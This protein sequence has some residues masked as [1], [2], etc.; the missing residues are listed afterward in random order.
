MSKATEKIDKKRLKKT[1]RITKS[2]SACKK[3]KVKC[4]F[5]IPC[6]PCIARGRAHLCTKDPILLDGMLVDN[7]NNIELKYSQEN[8]VLKKKIKILQD[9][10]LKLK[11]QNSLHDHNGDHSSFISEAN[12]RNQNFDDASIKETNNFRGNDDINYG[13]KANEVNSDYG[14]N[15]LKSWNTYSV[16]LSLLEKGLAN[17]MTDIND[18]NREET[19]KMDY[20]TE[21]WLNIPTGNIANHNKED[22][23]GNVWHYQLELIGR[24]GF[25]ECKYLIHK[26][27]EILTLWPIL[28]KEV[29]LKQF[30]QF[31]NDKFNR[32][33]HI[34]PFYSKS[35]TTYLFFGQFYSLMC[36]GSYLCDQN[37]SSI[38]FTEEE[39][40]MYPKAFFSCSLECLYRARFL[41]HSVVG[42]I[43]I[44]SL[45]RIV[46]SCLGGGN[47][48]N[49]LTCVSI[50]TAYSLQLPSMDDKTSKANW[51]IIVVHDWL[52][53]QARYPL[54][55]LSCFEST[56]TP[57][58]YL[59]GTNILDWSNYSLNLQIDIAA[60]KK[61]YYYDEND[62]KL[63]LLKKADIELRLLSV[64]MDQDFETAT[65]ETLQNQKIDQLSFDFIKF[66]LGYAIYHEILEV[67]LKMSKFKSYKEWT[68]ESYKTCHTIATEMIRQYTSI[69]TPEKF[70]KLS[71]IVE[72]VIYAAVFL[73]VDSL[74]NNQNV[75]RQKDSIY[76]VQRLV[77]V[78]RSFK[79]M[80]RTAVRGVHILE[81]LTNLLVHKSPE[82]V[83]MLIK[84]PTKMV[85]NNNEPVGI[86]GVGQ[87]LRKRSISKTH[88]YNSSISGSDHDSSG[89]SDEEPAFYYQALQKRHLHY[90]QMENSLGTVKTPVIQIPNDYTVAPVENDTS[91]NTILNLQ[92][93]ANMRT[94]T[95]SP[96]GS[97]MHTAIM[98]ILGDKEWSQ[99]L[100]SI[101]DFDG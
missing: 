67:N 3:R 25:S 48:L 86:I 29:F 52:E 10:I 76:A 79:V 68:V 47:L 5:E 99:F 9:T 19:E 38:A 15:H 100:G 98:D 57:E 51:W 84:M 28:D 14:K 36:I 92:Q 53:N 72:H 60:I 85:N 27:F 61:K 58:K 21:E 41:A 64:H 13:D 2:C 71:V 93:Q 73:L 77:S 11:N 96:T 54:T 35:K 101:G 18:S 4:N 78:L 91:P 65:L 56:K 88:S 45:M 33:K 42:S 95:I 34:T 12:T 89:E 44:I 16:T 39:W 24:L 43:Q 63:T 1:N 6:D 80:I 62:L 8:E 90:Q 70:K 23:K 81:K 22:Q 7:S 50:Y 69:E 97:Q 49:G 46:A 66:Y 30:E 31:W 32:E 55:D 40:D 26:G 94:G 83:E 37:D 20:N 17:G 75:K 59:S 74:L 82:S 87:M